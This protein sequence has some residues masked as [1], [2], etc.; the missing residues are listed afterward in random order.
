M[1]LNRPEVF[2]GKAN[3]KFNNDGILIDAKT[4]EIVSTM[5]AA[6]GEW[7]AKLNNK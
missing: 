2:I 1:I 7:T 3:E 4:K 5:L 6:L